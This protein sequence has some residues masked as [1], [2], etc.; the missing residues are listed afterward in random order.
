MFGILEQLPYEQVEYLKIKMD[1]TEDDYFVR[2]LHQY[3]FL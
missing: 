1:K 3:D 2:N